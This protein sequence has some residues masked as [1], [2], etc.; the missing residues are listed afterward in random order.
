MKC[1][2][3]NLHNATVYEKLVTDS[4][5]MYTI[6]NY[7]TIRSQS[8]QLS[9]IRKTDSKQTDQRLQGADLKK[10]QASAIK[11]STFVRNSQL[12]DWVILLVKISR[13][14]GEITF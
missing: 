14:L 1:V 10:N 13:H 2:N 7:P 12:H 8:H 6:I 4:K 9:C 11:I 3:V 5:C